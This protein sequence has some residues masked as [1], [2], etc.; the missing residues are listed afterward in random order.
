MIKSIDHIL[1]AV[2]DL[3]KAVE[4]YSLVFGFD[5]TWQGSHPSLGTKN[6]LFPLDNLY[7]ELIAVNDDGP[8]AETVNEHLEKNGESVFGLAL[9]TDD[10]E[11]AK[12]E[13]SAS[14]NADLEISDG[15][16]I[17]NVSN[18]ERHWRNIFIPKKFE[19]RTECL[20][21]LFWQM[22]SAPYLGGGF[23]HFYAYAP[24]KYEYP[25][26]R[27]AMEVKRQ[28]DVLDKLLSDKNFICCE[29]YTIADIAIWPWYGALVLGRLYDSEE[30]LD[31]KKY[32]NVLKWANLCNLSSTSK[33]WKYSSLS[34]MDSCIS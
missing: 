25:I 8:L 34:D 27:F 18:E 29:E 33:S 2:E 14:F 28:L 26:N 17:D 21:W 3:D 12:K 6:A 16:G 20:N 9:E 32:G 10:I 7:F 22:A 13:L 5:P 1:V 19:D 24:E 11:M 23:G 31:V 4:D 15:K 30:F